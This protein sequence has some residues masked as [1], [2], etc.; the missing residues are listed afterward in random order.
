MT[1]GLWSC[2]KGI[3]GLGAY[4]YS[5]CIYLQLLFLMS[6]LL[7]YKIWLYRWRSF[8]TYDKR[9]LTNHLTITG[10]I[11]KKKYTRNC[12]SDKF[13][14]F[15]LIVICVLLISNSSK[16]LNDKSRELDRHTPF[17]LPCVQ[18]WGS[19]HQGLLKNSFRNI[20]TGRSLARAE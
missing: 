15:I 11:L 1:V 3:R 17:W 7:V 9:P 2:L 5:L 10:N 6:S 4:L 14:S 12:L 19:I 20:G 8:S 16:S 18:F 13:C